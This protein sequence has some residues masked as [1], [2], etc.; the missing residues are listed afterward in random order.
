MLA[1]GGGVAAQSTA[2]RAD[3]RKGE[4]LRTGYRF[5]E[6]IA[7]FTRLLG[8]TADSSLRAEISREIIRCENGAQLLQ[9]AF[10]PHVVG[11]ATVPQK[12]FYTCYDLN[13]PGGWALTPDALR[14]KGDTGAIKPFLF[15][16]PEPRESLYFA[17]H[18]PDGRNGWDIY[19]THRMPNNEWSAPERLDDA[20]NTPFDERFPYLTPDGQTLYFSS[21]GHQGMGGYDLYKSTLADGRW[22]TPENLGFPLSSVHDDMLYVPDA[23]GLYACFVS[24]READKGRVSIYKIALEATPVKRALSSPDEI[25]QLERLPFATPE[26]AASPAPASSTTGKTS[27]QIEKLREKITQLDSRIAA[28]QQELDNLRADYAAATR[29]QQQRTLAKKI[30]LREY[31]ITQ[32]YAE[33]RQAHDDVRKAE[34]RML[35]QGLVPVTE[36]APAPKAES[37]QQSQLMFT[38]RSERMVTLPALLVQQPVVEVVEEKDFTFKTNAET[39]IFYNEP[40]EGVSY[41]IQ[42]GI[43]SRKLDPHELKQFTP[44]FAVAQGNKWSYAVGSFP[45]FNEAQKQLPV[46]KRQFKDAMIVAFKNGKSITV[47]QARIDEGKNPVKKQEP[48]STQEAAYQIVLGDYPSGLP[49]N[50]LKT[51]QQATGKDIARAALNGKTEYVVGPYARKSDAEQVLDVLHRSGFSHTRIEAIENKLKGKN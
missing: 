28:A 31:T 41:R 23:D 42:V 48:A 46:V 34:Y 7:V 29:E 11:K 9:F 49:Q 37:K 4:A 13:L 17:S 44:V 33:L 51:V 45:L 3:M 50:L 26:P 14:S 30:E 19:V 40:V 21:T 43:F 32:H 24:T 12:N 35:E 10:T 36:A 8:T 22:S 16:P 6:A 38:S 18:G 27:T 15:A 47:K 1:C 2:Q 20:I 5:K 25:L 39:R